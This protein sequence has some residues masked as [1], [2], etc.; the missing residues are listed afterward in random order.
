MAGNVVRCISLDPIFEIVKM[1]AGKRLCRVIKRL[2]GAFDL[3]GSSSCLTRKQGATKPCKSETSQQ[4]VME[5]T[6]HNPSS[7]IRV[8][9]EIVH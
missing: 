6:L 1:L 7:V 4:V 5:I 9:C 8:S 2:A 3:F